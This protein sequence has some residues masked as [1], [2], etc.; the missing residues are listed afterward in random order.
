MTGISPSLFGVNNGLTREQLAV[1]LVR[2]AKLP[3]QIPEQ[4]SF[5]DVPPAHWAYKE[6]ETA[7]A[8]GLMNGINTN[9]FGAGQTV[10]REQV[11]VILARL[12]EKTQTIN[13]TNP[14][15]DVDTTHWAYNEILL[16]KELGVFNGSNGAFQ[17]KEKITR[18]QLSLV[19]ENIH[20]LY[21]EFFQ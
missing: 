8:S 21:P 14:F 13:E 11:A 18:G 6:I 4:P 19:L 16:M 3:L 20:Q 17:P 10:P 12:S 2:A 5:Q 9:T 1:I 15:S 7:K